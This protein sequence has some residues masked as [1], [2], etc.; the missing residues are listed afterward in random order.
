MAKTKER[1]SLVLELQKLGL[2]LELLKDNSPDSLLGLC[3]LLKAKETPQSWYLGQISIQKEL[4]NDEQFFLYLE[5]AKAVECPNIRRLEGFVKS[6]H[7]RNESATSYPLDRFVATVAAVVGNG[8]YDET[9]YEYLAH[10][11]RYNPDKEQSRV[12]LANLDKYQRRLKKSLGELPESQLELFKEPALTGDILVILDDS[13]DRIFKL[14]SERDGLM[15]VIRFLHEIEFEG[16]LRNDEFEV[17]S[18]KPVET[19]RG[20]LA[21]RTLLD[22]HGGLDRMNQF[23]ERWV[24]NHCPLYDIESLTRRIE[25][26][27]GFDFDGAFG[28]RSAYINFIYGRRISNIPFDKIRNYQEDILIY[29]IT[30]KK[31][32]FIKL[33]EE[34]YE[35]FSN[36]PSDSILFNR[37][38]F[39]KYVNINTLNAKN[40]KDC[41]RMTAPTGL[42]ADLT[43]LHFSLL[44]E[45]THTFEEIKT[46]YGLGKQYYELYTTLTIPRVDEQLGVLKQ[47]AKRKLLTGVNDENHLATLAAL[48]SQKPLSKWQSEVFGHI[49]GLKAHDAIQ[50][51]IHWDKAQRLVGQMSTKSD[52][53]LVVCNADNAQNF[54]CLDKLKADL[55]SFDVSW[56]ALAKDMGFAGEFITQNQGHI[57]EFLSKNGADIAR[58]YY[59]GLEKDFQREGFK[60]IVK[61]I[62]MGGFNELK[63]H[64]DDLRKELDY[65]VRDAQKTVWMTNSSISGAN[66]YSGI[67]VKE[68][69]DFHSTM[70]LGTIPTET[71]L[72][73]IKGGAKDCLLSGFDSNKKVLYAYK[74][75]EVV[76]RAI[77][78]LTKGSFTDPFKNEETSLSFVDLEV[79][80]KGADGSMPTITPNTPKI[81][82]DAKERLIIFLERPYSAGVCED[83]A[84][85][86]HALYVKL[87]AEKAASMGAMLVLSQNYADISKDYVR[88]AFHVYISKS[89]AGAQYL[90]S[91]NGAAKVSDEGG[92]RSNT[93]YIHK[94]WM[95]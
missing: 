8:A 66:D 84:N 93:F 14:L 59:L 87:L 23:L 78:R 22:N 27:D 35:E 33:I 5:G 15:D 13:I 74:D 1:L 91:L 65:P 51:L 2:E 54:D 92:Y 25:A 21:L 72:C 55:I 46:L 11:S 79:V 17:I 77:V 24:E 60:C 89:K 81:S 76:G 95:S 26:G 63:Y 16:V 88:S 3:G 44:E 36:L 4:L 29:A 42:R 37:Q 43:K 83:T 71:C 69:D 38:F 73:Y 31:S 75:G 6:I 30:N 19:Y 61:A 94:D 53:M 49:K 40:L 48:L 41:G 9:F 57:F 28:I 85:A 62:L 58:T 47:L 20:L 45:R 7:D 52:A 90:D 67:D 12:I 39:A 86:I 80:G 68:C 56:T 50:L 64:G 70:L 18:Q 82:G 32:A 34:N 10:F